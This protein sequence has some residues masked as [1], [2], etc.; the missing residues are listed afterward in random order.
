M[1]SPSVGAYG[2]APPVPLD[3]LVLELVLVLV[4]DEVEVEEPEP[5]LIE[6]PPDVPLVFVFVGA[7]RS[8]WQPGTT[9]AATISASA[10]A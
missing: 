4:L 9:T 2:A 6:I 1:S 5:P 7:R 10:R 8:T 3:A